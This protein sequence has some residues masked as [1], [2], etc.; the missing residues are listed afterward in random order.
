ML[1][2]GLL[3]GAVLGLS[4]LFFRGAAAAVVPLLAIVV[5][6]GAATGLIVL[7]ALAFGFKLARARRS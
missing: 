2:Q 5:V 7:A 6:G 3:F 1:A 4:L